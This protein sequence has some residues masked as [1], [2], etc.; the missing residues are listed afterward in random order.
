MKR[1]SRI[2][3]DEDFQE[4]MALNEAKETGRQ[5]CNHDLKHVIDVARVAYTLFIEDCLA[6]KEPAKNYFPSLTEAKEVVYAA[7]LLHDI[8]RW[9]EYDRG[10]DHALVGGVLAP[11]ILVRAG[12]SPQE[13][14]IISRAIEEHRKAG[15][16]ASFM[17]K[18]LFKADKMVRLCCYCQARQDCY[19]PDSMVT[20]REPLLY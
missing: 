10:E 1:I 6:G 2:L 4:F 7:G 19:K 3:T 9:C 14:N 18:I 11:P 17:G 15:D 5:F 8:G 20:A 16:E 12:F 13:Q